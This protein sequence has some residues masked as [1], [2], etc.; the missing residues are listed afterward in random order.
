MLAAKPP[1]KAGIFGDR[2]RCLMDSQQLEI[3]L[4]RFSDHLQSLG[5]ALKS[6]QSQW[7]L[8]HKKHTLWLWITRYQ[9]RV[10]SVPLVT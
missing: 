2:V 7:F 10:L 6:G 3:I 1:M 4:P 9:R 5:Y 8:D